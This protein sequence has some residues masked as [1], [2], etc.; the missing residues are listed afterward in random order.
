MQLNISEEQLVRK[1]KIK[2]LNPLQVDARKRFEK[3][4]NLILKAPTGSGKTLA[5]IWS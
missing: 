5:F 2:G 4:N 3:E 1:L